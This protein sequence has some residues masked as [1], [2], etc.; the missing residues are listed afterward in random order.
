[1]VA[2]KQALKGNEKITLL[3]KILERSAA[4]LLYIITV[5]WSAEA[6]FKYIS[7]PAST[8]IQYQLG[9]SNQNSLQFPVITICNQDYQII[10]NHGWINNYKH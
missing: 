1:M 2:T 6:V 10:N 5:Y 8:T 4:F 3:R 7:E 9:D